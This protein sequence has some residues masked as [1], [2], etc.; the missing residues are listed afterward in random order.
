MFLFW[1]IVPV[2]TG[3]IPSHMHPP[4]WEPFRFRYVKISRIEYSPSHHFP[5]VS[6]FNQYQKHTWDYKLI[7]YQLNKKGQKS[8]FT[9]HPSKL[10]QAEA[11]ISKS[12]QQNRQQARLTPAVKSSLSDWTESCTDSPSSSDKN[13]MGLAWKWAT[14]TQHI[15]HV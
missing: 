5:S 1:G 4:V 13:H 12:T 9:L 15:L 2:I 14:S 7:P 10:H 8:R 11:D 6:L 3:G